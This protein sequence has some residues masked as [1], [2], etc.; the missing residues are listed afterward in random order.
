MVLAQIGFLTDALEA[1][2]T[3]VGAGM[4]IGG[5]IVGL[6]GLFA[7]WKRRDIQAEALDAGYFGGAIG[8]LVVLMDLS[9]RY[10]V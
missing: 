5:F 1:F 7:G 3:A 10:F 2:A 4:L 8:V 9:I 6:Y